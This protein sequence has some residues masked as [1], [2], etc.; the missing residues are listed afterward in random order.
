MIAVIGALGIGTSVA[1][2]PENRTVATELVRINTGS[3]VGDADFSPDG[4]LLALDSYGNQGTDLWDWRHKR[5]VRH[6]PEGGRYTWNHQ[7]VRFNHDG[8]LVVVCHGTG[9]SHVSIDVYAVAS[10][11]VVHSIGNG[12]CEAINFT[13]G[14]AQ[15]T[16]LSFGGPRTPGDNVTFYDTDKWQVSD[17]LRTIALFAPGQTIAITDRHTIPKTITVPDRLQL[18]PG[19][20]AASFFPDILSFSPNGKYL[21]M[22]GLYVTAPFVSRYAIAIVELAKRSIARTFWA[23]YA[24]DMDW[25]TDSTRLAVAESDAIKVFNAE[26]GAILV[27]EHTVPSHSLVRYTPDNKYLVEA[28]GKKVEIWDSD[29]HQLMQVIRAEPSC[30]TISKDGHYLAMAGGD[31]NPIDQIA[32]LSLVLHP[33]GGGGRAIVYALE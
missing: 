5:V 9:P 22:S 21:A 4:E 19:Q 26:T 33:S 11:Q 32:L 28:V 14:G 2:W 7:L 13:P 1:C 18:Q 12:G 17:G 6:L 16:R 8:Q 20:D 23:E 31:A 15:L 27:E 24:E 29:H 10:G 30:I 3:V 25:A